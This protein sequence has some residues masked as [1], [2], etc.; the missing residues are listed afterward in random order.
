MRWLGLVYRITEGFEDTKCV[1]RWY[2]R[3][4]GEES[5]LIAKR[6]LDEI[7]R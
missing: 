6:P 5:Q 3:L 1:I 7:S 2:C 4:K